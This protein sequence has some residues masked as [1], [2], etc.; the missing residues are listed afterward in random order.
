MLS[1]ENLILIP[2]PGSFILE[3]MPLLLLKR[4]FKPL[5]EFLSRAWLPNNMACSSDYSSLAVHGTL[6]FPT[7]IF[8]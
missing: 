1:W 8:P 5:G 4:F 2:I 7:L 3:R 6:I